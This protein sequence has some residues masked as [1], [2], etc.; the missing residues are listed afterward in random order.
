MELVKNEICVDANNA[1]NKHFE[2]L[3]L[4]TNTTGVLHTS[5]SILFSA[6]FYHTTTIL[7]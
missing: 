2:A 1:L 4:F 5:D 3:Q 7:V 6:E